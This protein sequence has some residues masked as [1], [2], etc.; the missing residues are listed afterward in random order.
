MSK[1]CDSE[2][3]DFEKLLSRLADV[4]INKPLAQ[5]IGNKL[6]GRAGVRLAHHTG[7][8]PIDGLDTYAQSLANLAICLPANDEVQNL[9]LAAGERL[10]ISGIF[11]QLGEALADYP[12]AFHD[13][14]DCNR[15]FVHIIAFAKNAVSA[16]FDQFSDFATCLYASE[17][18]DLAFRRPTARFNQNFGTAGM[19][20]RDIQHQQVW[21]EL[22]HC[23]NRSNPVRD[24]VSDGKTIALKRVSIAQQ[25]TQS[26]ANDRVIIG[27]YRRVFQ[28]KIHGAHLLTNT[29]PCV[30]QAISVYRT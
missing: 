1:T 21:L 28:T 11:K 10:K 2:R 18:N 19:R 20:H 25:L 23:A 26:A 13:A 30:F 6:C 29:T 4:G 8:M 16:D 12:A 3:R 17:N 15:Q 14:G 9:S 7:A 27:N 5:S 22:A 24:L